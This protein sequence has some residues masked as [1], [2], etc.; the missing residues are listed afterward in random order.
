VEGRASI[1]PSSRATFNT[2]PPEPLATVGIFS[3]GAKNSML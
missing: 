3:S 2:L 1:T